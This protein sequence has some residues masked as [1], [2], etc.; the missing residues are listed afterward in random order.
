MPTSRQR[1]LAYFG[2][3]PTASAA[4]LSR[5]LGRTPADIRH[6]LPILLADGRLE[7]IGERL[8]EG[9]GRPAQVYSL[10]PSARGENLVNLLD[11]VFQEWLVDLAPPARES[12]LRAIACRLAATGQAASPNQADQDARTGQTG[13]PIP[14]ARRLAH[15]MQGLNAMYYQARWEASAAGPRVILE[16][17]PY[18]RIISKYPVLCQM[19]AFLLARWLGVKVRQTAKLERGAQGLSYCLFVPVSM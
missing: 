6:H 7:V 4:D 5:A 14:I 8:G 10:S 12:A 9:R 19:D 17:C 2:K 15:A 1:I 18:W 3:H 13:S 16:H 11:A